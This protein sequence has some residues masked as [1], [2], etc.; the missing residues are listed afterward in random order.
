MTSR[1]RR[2]HRPWIAAVVLTSAVVAGCSPMVHIAAAPETAAGADPDDPV[3]IV[4]RL[5]PEAVE[6]TIA[7]RGESPVD[8]LWDRALLV[9]TAGRSSRVVRSSIG[10]KWGA[11][12][13]S[14][15]VSRIPAH[16]TLTD[17]IIPSN[18]V[19][20]D[21]ASGWVVQPFLPV[22]CGPIRCTGYHDLV[23]RTVHLSVVTQADGTERVTESTYRITSA[24]KSMRGARPDEAQPQ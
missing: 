4:L 20:F 21:P 12:D 9:D 17:V 24:V 18:G 2:V 15:D 13:R 11:T 23:G 3:G 6:V 19:E 8:V 7:N 1:P 5:R 10:P 22:E 14:G 16:S